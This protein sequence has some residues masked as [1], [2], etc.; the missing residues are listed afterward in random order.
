MSKKDQNTI[1]IAISVA[2]IGG[3]FALLSSMGGALT[4]WFLEGDKR[5]MIKEGNGKIE[6]SKENTLA[7]TSNLIY[8][9]T[10]TGEVRSINNGSALYSGDL[11]KIIFTP[12]QDSYVYIFQLD[13]SGQIYQLFPMKE[14]KGVEVDNMN[15]V[16]KN[17][18]YVIPST[19][20]AFK[21]D[22]TIGKERIYFVATQKPDIQLGNAY[23]SILEARQKKEGKG[24]KSNGI[25]NDFIVNLKKRGI[26]SIV[27][28][29]SIQFTW[30]HDED[31]QYF[32][33]FEQR[34][35]DMCSD[36]YYFVTFNHM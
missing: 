14:F 34:L 4:E 1:W 19:S 16:R 18:R 6:Y 36:C 10:H 21:L 35:E 30:R 5:T 25:N 2:L 3:I 11:Y 9:S 17:T 8:R 20:K 13:T 27:T 33:V 29:N 22:D 23:A 31:K 12:H 32:S 15:P 26:E 7:F 28:D 24:N